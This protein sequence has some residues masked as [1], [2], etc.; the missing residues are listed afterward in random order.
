VPNLAATT[1]KLRSASVTSSCLA[2]GL[3][4]GRAWRFSAASDLKQPDREDD[5]AG[6]QAEDEQ[7]LRQARR[8]G[9]ANG[10]AHVQS[11]KRAA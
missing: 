3:A 1:T 5:A 2:A 11:G 4:V 9:T 8:P 6:K 10:K 7:P